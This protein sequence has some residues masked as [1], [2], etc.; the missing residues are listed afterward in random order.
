M[1]TASERATMIGFEPVMRE[2]DTDF[3]TMLA[4]Q[5]WNKPF[6]YALLNAFIRHQLSDKRNVTSFRRAKS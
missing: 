4:R 5:P 2:R 1:A 3:D 6:A